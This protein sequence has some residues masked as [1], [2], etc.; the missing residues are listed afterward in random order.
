MACAGAVI[1]ASVSIDKFLDIKNNDLLSPFISNNI[2]QRTEATAAL[3]IVSGVIIPLGILMIILH[4]F[5]ISLG[6]FGRIIIAVVCMHISDK[7]NPSHGA[8]YKYS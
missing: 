1:A 2:R 7:I 5:K 8:V 6:A 4:F 3:A